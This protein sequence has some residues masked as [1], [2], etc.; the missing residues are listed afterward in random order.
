MIPKRIYQT[1]K[2]HDLPPGVQHVINTMMEINPN[3][4]H[5]LY[6][7]AEMDRFIAKNYPGEIYQAFQTLNIGAAKADLWRYLILYKCGGIYLDIDAVI[8]KSLDELIQD[9]DVAIITREQY[10]GLFN[11]WILIF[12][13]GHPLLK[14]V[15]DQCVANIQKRSSN[16]VLHLTGSTVFTQIINDKLKH[17]KVQKDIWHTPDTVLK[18]IFNK[19]SNPY[20]CRF[21]GTDMAPFARYHSDYYQQLYLNAPQWE[22]EQK[23]KSIFKDGKKDTKEAIEIVDL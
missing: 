6:D 5:Y 19:P 20:Q 14:D 23:T 4:T 3:Y 11:Q 9:D 22:L 8:D 16:N 21:F 7:D 1:W 15:I 2:T 17:K 10:E 18:R 12:Q 13:K